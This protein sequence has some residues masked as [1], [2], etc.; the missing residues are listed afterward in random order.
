MEDSIFTKI[1]NGEIPG[2]IIYQDTTSAVL[3]TIEP[4][5]PGHLLVVPKTQIDH[6]WDVDTDTYHHLFD[7][8]RQASVHLRSVYNYPRVG[9][10][11]EGFGVPHA[12]IHV[13]GFTQPLEPTMAERDARKKA[14]QSLMVD[15][16]VLHTE[17]EKLRAVWPSAS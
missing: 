17:A 3:L 8:A 9:M 11:V 7:I 1:L 16:T 14:G 5:S 13:F 6:L 12:H 2:E 10:M 15:L 4:F